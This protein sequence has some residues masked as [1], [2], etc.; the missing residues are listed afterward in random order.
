MRKFIIAFM[1]F[2]ISLMG[3]TENKVDVPVDTK[4]VSEVVNEVIPQEVNATVV[5][6]TEKLQ[7]LAKALQVPAEHVYSVLVKNVQIRAYAELASLLITY[8]AGIII[9]VITMKSYFNKNEQW[10]ISHKDSYDVKEDPQ[11]NYYDLDDS[12]HIGGAILSGIILSIAIIVSI[13][14]IPDILSSLLNPEYG[15][16]KEIMQLF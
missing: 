8:L 10:R 12:W 5:Y 2:S 7:E 15:A 3:Y 9:L 1:L 13:L 16:L 14:A 11:Y 4:A 6:L